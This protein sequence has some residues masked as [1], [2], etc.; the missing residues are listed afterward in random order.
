MGVVPGARGMR[1]LQRCEKNCE[2]EKRAQK[3]TRKGEVVVM[4]ACDDAMYED[5]MRQ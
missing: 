2:E 3:N 4:C 5:N 1:L